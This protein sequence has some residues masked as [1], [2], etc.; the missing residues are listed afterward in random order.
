MAEGVCV[1]SP[2]VCKPVMCGVG[3]WWGEEVAP[4]CVGLLAL[5]ARVLH[6]LLVTVSAGDLDIAPPA[7][8]TGYCVA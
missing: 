7:P 2:H 5:C 3:L 1:T 4:A 6:G 8:R